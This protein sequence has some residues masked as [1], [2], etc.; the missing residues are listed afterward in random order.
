MVF[1]VVV[2]L[3]YRSYWR[4]LS[5]FSKAFMKIEFFIET[6]N[7]KIGA[8]MKQEPKCYTINSLRVNKWNGLI[9]FGVS[10]I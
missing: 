1:V 9:E 6:T 8:Y 5:R 3:L 4:G 7:F 10:V 2:F